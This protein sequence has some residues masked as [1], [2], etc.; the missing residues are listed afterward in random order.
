MIE[1]ND[2][3]FVILNVDDDD[4]RALNVNDILNY[5][6]STWVN[7]D[8]WANISKVLLL[9][10]NCSEYAK[11]TKT[12]LELQNYHFAFASNIARFNF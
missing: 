9:K 1:M 8:I 11:I 6:F 12:T 2:M 10:L 4:Y 5:S 7:I 3:L